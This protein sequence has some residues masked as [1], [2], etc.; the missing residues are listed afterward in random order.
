[1]P[2]GRWTSRTPSSRSTTARPGPRPPPSPRAARTVRTARPKE[3]TA[4]GAVIP[5]AS[6]RPAHAAVS[7]P[8]PL[9]DQVIE[10]E[11]GIRAVGTRLVSANEPYFAGHFPGV[12]VVPGVL[13]C[14][15]LAQL[16][17]SVA[18]ED[19]RVTLDGVQR[20]RFRRPVVPGDAL[21]LEGSALTR[22]PDW[23]FRGLVAMG[24]AVVA[25]IEFGMSAPRG[26]QVH[27]TAVASPLAELADGV[28]IGPYAVIGP[29]VR[30]GPDTWVGSHAVVEGRTTV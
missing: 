25:E 29:H 14:E 11:P 12:P 10:V 7:F 6:Q 5:P 27:P 20:A 3:R 16:G 24:E 28:R 8:Y 22:G 4:E 23:R 2:T 19:G 13:L 9:L 21:R 18:A 15:A 26:P 1:M 30:L 17:A